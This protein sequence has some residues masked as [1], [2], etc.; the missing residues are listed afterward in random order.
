VPSLRRL[1]LELRKMDVSP[2]EIE[3]DSQEFEE[4]LNQ[5]QD[6]ADKGDADQG[7]DQEE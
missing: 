1:L 2:G 3:L 6:I 5:A 4:L 7:D